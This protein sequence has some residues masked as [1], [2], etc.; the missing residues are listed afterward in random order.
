MTLALLS[1]AALPSCL[2]SGSRS[3][4][5]AEP[6]R[7]SLRIQQRV[8]LQNKPLVGFAIFSIPPLLQGVPRRPRRAMLRLSLMAAQAADRERES[9]RA[10]ERERGP[11]EHLGH[12]APTFVENLE[13]TPRESPNE[14]SR[15][16]RLR[17]F[18]LSSLWLQHVRVLTK[19]QGNCAGRTRKQRRN[20]I[21]RLD[22]E[23][24]K[25]RECPE[26]TV[27]GERSRTSR[28][29]EPVL[30]HSSIRLLKRCRYEVAPLEWRGARR[31]RGWASSPAG[32]GASGAPF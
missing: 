20:F 23:S 7:A 2:S 32:G 14:R 6:R 17:S 13:K 31:M 18:G 1:S 3:S 8:P 30:G 29:L 10:R 15:R 26:F 9:E 28:S 16:T 5:T 21:T 24:H 19:A 12:G 4:G 11:F 22:E 25:D 27:D